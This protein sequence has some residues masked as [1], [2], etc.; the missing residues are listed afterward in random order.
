MQQ[1]KNRMSQAAQEASAALSKAE[2]EAQKSL[3][4]KEAAISAAN[5]AKAQA[6]SAR[7]EVA[8]SQKKMDLASQSA[9]SQSAKATELQQQV[10][11][12][13]DLLLSAEQKADIA[14]EAKDKA[15]ATLKHNE[16]RKS[17]LDD[18]VTKHE[19][20]QRKLK[21]V[22]MQLS[23]SVNELRE[24]KTKCAR[25]EEESMRLKASLVRCHKLNPSHHNESTLIDV[26]CLRF[27]GN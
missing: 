1:L 19:E 10:Q 26:V 13:K 14:T 15:E 12:L 11:N 4:D 18:Q 9:H 25:V 17:A 20:T 3:A 23:N 8:A 16:D 21:S 7:A 22:E 5:A 24:A 6:A 27:A 2:S